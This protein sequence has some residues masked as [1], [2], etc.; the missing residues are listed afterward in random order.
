MI[1][2]LRGPPAALAE[3]EP[4][5]PGGRLAPGDVHGLIAVVRE[6]SLAGVNR[7]VLVLNLSMLP[8]D[9]VRPHHLR[10]VQ[11]ALAPLTGADRARLFQLPNA[12]V[13]AIWRGDAGVLLE[14][15]RRAVELLFADPVELAPDPEALIALL[16]LPRDGEMLLAAAARSQQ[17]RHPVAAHAARAV[18]PLDTATL[19]LLE[20]ALAQ[21]SVDRFTRREPV[22]VRPENGRGEPGFH[23]AWERRTL[24]VA[25]LAETMVPDHDLHADP[26]LFRRLMRTLERRLLS[27]L[28]APAELRLAAPFSLDVHVSGILGP[29]FLRFDA[30]L[31]TGL[32]GQVVLNL[33]PEDVLA[34]P[35]AFIFARDFAHARSYRLLLSATVAQLPLLPLDRLG[36]DL[37]QVSWSAALASAE[38]AASLPRPAAIVLAGVDS[39]AA[40]AW[41]QAHGVVF[42]QGVLA[43]PPA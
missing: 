4:G 14:R 18:R 10:L 40:L 36:L 41:G 11:E 38:I 28:S 29:E 23:R 19:A 30:L 32:R 35:A 39:V 6:S 33:R 9:R 12:D 5:A 3:L 20:T 27:L 34:D 31:P 1:P 2:G 24:S 13:V 42:Y 37:L 15:S 21:T 26:W 16:Q 22:C 25:E 8:E 43:V 17:P 7:N